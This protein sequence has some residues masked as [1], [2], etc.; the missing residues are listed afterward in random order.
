MGCLLARIILAADHARAGERHAKK[1]DRHQHGNHDGPRV[2]PFRTDHVR[3]SP[4]KRPSI[5]PRQSRTDSARRPGYIS[6][7]LAGKRFLRRQHRRDGTD[8][9]YSRQQPATMPKV[10]VLYDALDNRSQCFPG[11]QIYLGRMPDPSRHSPKLV[12]S[13][14]SRGRA[15]GPGKPGCAG[16]CFPQHGDFWVALQGWSDFIFGGSAGSEWWAVQGL[17]LRPLPCESSA[18][19]LS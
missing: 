11:G 6:H 2:I 13:A 9:P 10:S 4:A 3:A 19:P 8:L 14:G 12:T 1:G 18:L 16:G 15:T 5:Y 7:Q 17:N